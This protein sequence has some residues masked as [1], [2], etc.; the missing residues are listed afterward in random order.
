MNEIMV[1]IK[2]RTQTA[3]H[4]GSGK[5]NEATDAL[6]RRNA[7]G[8]LLLPGSAIAGALR[9]IA[10][11][12]APRLHAEQGLCQAIREGRFTDPCECW[13]CNLFG[14]VNPQEADDNRSKSKRGGVASRLWVYDAEYDAQQAS[15]TSIRD[16]VGIDRASRTAARQ[17]AVKFDLEVL[18]AGAT[19]ILQMT[20]SP[21][22]EVETQKR[23][24]GLLTL[25]L[26]EWED[27]RGALG[28]RMARGLGAFK[29]ESI[30]WRERNLQ[31][32]KALMDF[33]KREAG[34]FFAGFSLSSAQ[35]ERRKQAK[36]RYPIQAWQG[37]DRLT[38]FTDYAVA[39][40]WATAELTLHF[41]GPMLINDVAMARRSGFDHAP[42][43]A[44]ANGQQWLL[45]GSSLRG[46]IRSQA[47]RIARTIATQ[48]AWQKHKD[49][50]CAYFLQ[51]N[52][53]GDPNMTSSKKAVAGKTAKLANSDALLTAAGVDGT[54]RVK[55][56]HLDLADRLFGSVRLGSRLLIEDGNLVYVNDKKPKLKAMDFLAID[57]F[58]GGG[59]DSAKFDAI[60]LW[61]PTFKCRLRLDNP[62]AWELGWLLLT[63]RDLHQG[64]TTVGFGAAKGF[65]AVTL[66]QAT[67]V[68]GWLH[69][70]D[71]PATDKTALPTQAQV[72]PTDHDL[73]RTCS[74]TW[75][76]DAQTSAWLPLAQAW[77][78]E[79]ND[80]VTQF[81]RIDSREFQKFNESGRPE[82][83][84]NGTPYQVGDSYFTADGK[85][86]ELYP[87]VLSP[88]GQGGAA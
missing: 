88:A 8:R 4:L 35:T 16:G 74:Y 64:L 29:V 61:Q 80:T 23:N 53:A 18:P 7:Q 14:D 33:L 32:D 41:P 82:D 69:E 79:F 51:H 28:G 57:R 34:D 37:Q 76:S 44:V 25:T 84:P 78:K 17:G 56:S 42:L 77:V 45:P 2:I 71:F 10:T 38:N 48:H 55:P 19:F 68:L 47:E 1:E 22:K 6:L 20:L 31:V 12:L 81:D 67:I 3:L 21:A 86:M 65:G 63:L 9:T 40:S 87:V 13:V 75:S 49:E 5:G 73:W 54:V 72:Q 66:Q 30:T 11:R 27:G 70:S 15:A 85:L 83:L 46:I 60:A 36:K 24:E 52:P 59:R 39:R 26:A 43:A 58:T 50:R 62:Q